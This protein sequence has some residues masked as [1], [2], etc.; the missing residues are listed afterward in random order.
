MDRIPFNIEN[1]S[2]HI[3]NN[4]NRKRRKNCPEAAGRQMYL[5]QA[6]EH[7]AVVEPS[8]E[9]LHHEAVFKL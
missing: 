5:L 6:V 2:L 8:S 1:Q 9:A 7:K 4:K 3:D